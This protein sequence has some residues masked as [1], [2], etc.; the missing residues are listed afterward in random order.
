MGGSA[1]RT[2]I[3]A[4]NGTAAWVPRCDA[5]CGRFAYFVTK[6][7]LDAVLIGNAYLLTEEINNDLIWAESAG[8]FH[9]G[10]FSDLLR[11]KR[12]DLLCG[13]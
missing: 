11:V 4:E 6:S 3:G 13:C 1:K 2:Y 8:V 9:E 7:R 5:R 10:K 12:Y